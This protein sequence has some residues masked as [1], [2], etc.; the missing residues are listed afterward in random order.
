MSEFANKPMISDSESE[1]PYGCKE[2]ELKMVFK[3]E[4]GS[5]PITLNLILA[6]TLCLYLLNI[7]DDNTDIQFVNA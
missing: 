7:E 5:F 6:L 1:D 3:T 4:D 2:E